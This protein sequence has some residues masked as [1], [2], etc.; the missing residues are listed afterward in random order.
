M[1]KVP[2]IWGCHLFSPKFRWQEGL[3]N[4]SAR[5]MERFNSKERMML[6]WNWLQC[7]LSK[8][9][10]SPFGLFPGHQKRAWPRKSPQMNWGQCWGNDKSHFGIIS[11][12]FLCSV[13]CILDEVAEPKNL[14]W[15]LFSLHYFRSGDF[16]HDIRHTTTTKK[17]KKTDFDLWF[18]TLKEAKIQNFLK[19]S[20]LKTQKS[21]LRN[22]RH[23]WTWNGSKM[24]SK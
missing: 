14:H 12:N 24:D 19:D 7:L 15:S 5:S 10:I 21:R 8:F 16:Y 23:K 11:P 9:F 2:Y 22:R 20:K 4:V 18:S 13:L 3:E 17:L 1:L 6:A